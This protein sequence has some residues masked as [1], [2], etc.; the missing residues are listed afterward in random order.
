MKVY[1]LIGYPLNHSFS[2][3]SFSNIFYKKNIK[4][5]IYREFPIKSIEQLPKLFEN[6][7]DIYGLSITAPYKETIIPFLYKLDDT[8]CRVGAVN[9]VKIFREHNKELK[10]FGY[11]TDVYGFEKTLKPLLKPEHNKALILG[12]G[13]ASKAI[14]FVLN[15][16]G[17]NYTLVSRNPVN[18]KQISYKSIDKSVINSHYLIINATPVGMFPNNNQAPDIAYQYITNKHILYDLIYN[19]KETMFLRA[20]KLNGATTKNGLSMLYLQAEKSW[21]IW[22]K[23]LIH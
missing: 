16:L 2:K 18:S 4:N 10:L 9:S 12:T 7:P 8:A 17:I 15:K 5:V 13:G 11:N 20:G 22:N 23:T 21:E 3:K 1:G 14:I 6:Y 19:P